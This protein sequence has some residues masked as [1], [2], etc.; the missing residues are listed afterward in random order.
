MMGILDLIHPHV[1]IL[2]IPSSHIT[3]LGNWILDIDPNAP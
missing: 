3:P 1:G 2:G